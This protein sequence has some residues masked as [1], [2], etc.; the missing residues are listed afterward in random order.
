MPFW[1]QCQDANNGSARI[2]YSN[3]KY[4]ILL[5]TTIA[6]TN[7]IINV[8]ANANTTLKLI[9][10]I[11]II[12]YN[13]QQSANVKCRAKTNADSKV[14]TKPMLVVML[15]LQFYQKYCRFYFKKIMSTE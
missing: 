1:Y 8:N 7:A 11:T 15:I 12:F 13:L 10:T 3:T 14:N 2:K 5:L 4:V 6:N 9:I